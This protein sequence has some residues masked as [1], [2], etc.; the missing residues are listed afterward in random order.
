MACDAA[1]PG[2]RWMSIPAPSA[3]T[4]AVAGL[5]LIIAIVAWATSPAKWQTLKKMTLAIVVLIFLR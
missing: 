5:F 4:S 2:G 3:G 1:K